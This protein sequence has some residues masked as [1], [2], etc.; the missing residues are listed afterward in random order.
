MQDVL[1]YR[2]KC[3]S[4]FVLTFCGGRV[5]NNGIEKKSNL[6]LQ[7]LN[8]KKNS[9]KMFYRDRFLLV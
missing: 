5:C 2:R 4:L 1:I 7:T 6:S 8:Q 3:M 9:Q